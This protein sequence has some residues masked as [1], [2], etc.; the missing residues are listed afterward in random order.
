MSKALSNKWLSQLGL[1][2]ANFAATVTFCLRLR[3]M[4][5][6]QS[7]TLG[8]RQEEIRKV[9][10]VRMLVVGPEGVP[11]R[12][13]SE[14]RACVSNSGGERRIYRADAPAAVAG[15]RERARVPI[16][17]R[18]SRVLI[19]PLGGAAKHARQFAYMQYGCGGFFVC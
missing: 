3:T 19:E 10:H 9:R 5:S 15:A 18:A 12:S 13:R 14:L 2:N 11:Q 7:C 6:V 1:R 16:M 4:F 17:K 8:R